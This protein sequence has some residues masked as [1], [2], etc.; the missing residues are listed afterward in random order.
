[1]RVANSDGCCSSSN[2]RFVPAREVAIAF[3]SGTTQRGLLGAAHVINR[4]GWDVQ[5]LGRP[6]PLI[7]E[8]VPE[9]VEIF[10]HKVA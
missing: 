5:E 2:I 8:S 4:M 3:L 9:Y 7:V 1:M 6:E 10:S